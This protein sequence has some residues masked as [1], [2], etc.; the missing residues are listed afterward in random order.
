MTWWILL[1]VVIGFAGSTLLFLL[2]KPAPPK[3][4]EVIKEDTSKLERLQA[5]AGQEIEK[6][7]KK[8][9]E[10]SEKVEAYQKLIQV[11]EAEIGRLQKEKESSSQE[12]LTKG[13]RVAELELYVEDPQALLQ[14]SSEHEFLYHQ[15]KLQFEEKE[16]MLQQAHATLL[17]TENRLKAAEEKT[18]EPTQTEL[19]LTR[20][21][22]ELAGE[23]ERIETELTSVQ[24]LVTQLSQKKPPFKSKKR[25]KRTQ[26]ST[27]A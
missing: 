17:D 2:Q 23:K 6:L 3:I 12:L 24:Q 4:V 10:G 15:L 21:L 27:E 5:Q 19:T 8:L 22:T 25:L 13:R 9:Q 1:G 14:G 16:E 7:R 20:Q 18:H 26:N 11:H